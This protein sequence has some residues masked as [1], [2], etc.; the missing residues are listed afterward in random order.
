MKETA[1]GMKDKATRPSRRTSKLV[2]SSSVIEKS[3]GLQLE[4]IESVLSVIAECFNLLA[5]QQGV[6]IAEP[7]QQLV[8]YNRF[9]D[10]D[11]CKDHIPLYG[12]RYECVACTK[13]YCSKCV[14]MHDP[15]HVLKLHR[16]A[17]L[18]DRAVPGDLWEV[19]RIIGH[20]GAGP[21]RVY[22]VKWSGPWA[23]TLVKRSNFSLP[24]MLDGCVLSLFQFNILLC[25]TCV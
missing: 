17:E 10:G 18:A 11:I 9:C 8:H 20:T 13:D 1:L 12:W 16:V 6:V 5:P 24:G 2:R 25:S 19:D 4:R 15:F 23:D 7:L 3:N 22:T 14:A 21:K